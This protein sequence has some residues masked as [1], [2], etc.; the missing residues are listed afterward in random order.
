MKCKV[1]LLS[2]L[3]IDHILDLGVGAWYDT[4]WE[5]FQQQK[6]PAVAYA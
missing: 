3:A 6:L 1:L 4:L 5:A 2:D